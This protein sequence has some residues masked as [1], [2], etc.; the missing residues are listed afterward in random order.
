M[1]ELVLASTVIGVAKKRV[2]ER[3]GCS[4]AGATLNQRSTTQGPCLANDI[5]IEQILPGG[6]DFSDVL[7]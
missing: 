6:V 1:S 5:E 7:Q 2:Q 4:K 3:L